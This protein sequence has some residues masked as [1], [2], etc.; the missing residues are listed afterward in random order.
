VNKGACADGLAVYPVAEAVVPRAPCARLEGPLSPGELAVQRSVVLKPFA[1][2]ILRH[3][4]HVRLGEGHVCVCVCVGGGGGS[5]RGGGGHPLS[6]KKQGRK[7]GA[8]YLAR[9]A[10]EAAGLRRKRRLRG[11]AAHR[12][13][14]QDPYP[15]SVTFCLFWYP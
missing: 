2:L 6:P 13:H 3:P 14:G 5:S 11:E 4:V 10:C 1:P 15:V 7:C 9:S 12:L 8:I